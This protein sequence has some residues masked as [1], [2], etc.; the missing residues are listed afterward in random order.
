MP[1]RRPNAAARLVPHLPGWMFLASGLT[2]IGMTVL[3]PP[4]L[5]CRALGWQH[6]VM[7]LQTQRL[8]QQKRGYQ[9][10]H[11]ALETQDP[12]LV[13]RLACHQLHLK[14]M[15]SHALMATASDRSETIEDW[16][17]TPLPQVGVEYP[18]LGLLKTRLVRLATGPM[19]LGLVGVGMLCLTG[20]LVSAGG[21]DQEQG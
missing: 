5:D 7:Q 8:V 3:I 9:H 17:H 4:W 12:A 16:L 1:Q 21:R 20:A 18:P 14:P 19:R 6:D 10:F 11:H 15:G 13:E 2:L